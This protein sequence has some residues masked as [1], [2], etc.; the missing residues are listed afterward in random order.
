MEKSVLLASVLYVGL[1]YERGAVLAKRFD[2]SLKKR[3]LLQIGLWKR[4]LEQL[5]T[6]GVD[7]NDIEA[8]DTFLEICGTNTKIKLS[9]EHWFI[10]VKKLKENGYIE[11]GG[12]KITDY[13][14]EY[15]ELIIE[16]MIEVIEKVSNLLTTKSFIP[17]MKVRNLIN[18]IH[19]L[20]RAFLPYIENVNNECKN[21]AEY[22]GV[23]FKTAIEYSLL[24]R[25]FRELFHD[26]INEA[27][28]DIP[29]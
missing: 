25:T 17:K 23:D 7:E 9:Y 13:Q 19:N 21:I 8:L 1:V 3:L 18:C 24:D 12:Y 28:S 29:R 22:S 26:K 27:F 11:V 16:L 5:K 14:N 4:I 6:Q 2:F 15:R 20:P 10:K